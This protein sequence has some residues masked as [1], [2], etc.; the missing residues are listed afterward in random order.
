MSNKSRLLDA[1]GYSREVMHFDQDGT[2]FI[3]ELHDV[4]PTMELAKQASEI[5]DGKKIDGMR[6]EAMV[7]QHELNRAFRE[8]W[9]HD[10][11]A[12]KRWANDPSNKLFRVEH[13]GRINRL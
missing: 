2:V 3:E 9:F 7:P 12:W 11:D 4:E 13:H 1:Y 8:G 5:M 10:R 6:L